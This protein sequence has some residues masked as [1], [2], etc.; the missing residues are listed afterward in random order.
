[1]AMD[2]D[3]AQ[4]LQRI[5]ITFPAFLLALVVHEYS[6]AWMATRFGDQTAAWNGRVSPA[7]TW[8]CST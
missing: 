4:L 1:M 2:A 3:V 5:I 6:H 7:S 8:W